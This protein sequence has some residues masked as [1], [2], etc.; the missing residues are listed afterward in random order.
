MKPFITF[1]AIAFFS[2]SFSQKIISQE[3]YEGK[4]D[5]KID[6]SLYFKVHEN[7]CPT[8]EMSAMYKYKSNKVGEWI[9]LDVF[10]TE[11]KNQYTLVEHFNT[12]VLL[13]KK[14]NGTLNGLWISTD[15]KK[16]LK[17]QLKKVKVSNSEI[18]TLEKALDNEYYQA[19]DC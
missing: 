7:G 18:E 4:I 9:L 10:F 15:G 1:L 16:Q 11:G 5:G 3:F 12:G 13:L 14:E 8:T 19:N 2:F 6:I 17:V